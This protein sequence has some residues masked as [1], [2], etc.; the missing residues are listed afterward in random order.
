MSLTLKLASISLK[1]FVFPLRAVQT[2]LS[3]A[4]QIEKLETRTR[5][6]ISHPNTSVCTF[7]V[8]PA[9]LCQ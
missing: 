5:W 4:G 6:T 9:G 7:C 2:K 3:S 1:A 8:D